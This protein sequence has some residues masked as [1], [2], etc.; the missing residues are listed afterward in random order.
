MLNTRWFVR[1]CGLIALVGCQP[2]LYFI[3]GTATLPDCDDAPI[4][5]LDNT[6]WFDQGNVTNDWNGVPDDVLDAGLALAGD[7]GARPGVSVL[8]AQLGLQPERQ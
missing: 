1:C 4:V 5:D 3:P 8:C 6:L 2:D 7:R